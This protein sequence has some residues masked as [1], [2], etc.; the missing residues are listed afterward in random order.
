MGATM[1]KES[2]LVFRRL[3]ER[4][5]THT[6]GKGVLLGERAFL[7]HV[8]LRGDPGEEAFLKAVKTA[9]KVDLPLQPNTVTEGKGI[10]AYWLGPDEWLLVTGPDAQDA[11]IAKLRTA[12]ESRF[13]SVTDVSAG[14]TVIVVGGANARDLLARGC[15]LDLHPRVFGPGQCAQSLVA[16]A[17]ALLRPLADGRF[18]LIVRRSFADYLWQWMETVGTQFAVAV[19]AP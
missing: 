14:Q 2:P 5:S 3:A 10:A 11:L 8:N 19:V 12:L 6:A 1:R 13:A 7:G 16:K 15:P 17:P 9:A 18:E 4:V